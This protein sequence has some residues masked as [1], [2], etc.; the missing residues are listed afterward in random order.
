V[1]E[2]AGAAVKRVTNA[3][4]NLGKPDHEIEI[5][6][7]SRKAY[8]FTSRVE[9][10]G[11]LPVGTAGD[12]LAIIAGRDSAI[13]AW[14]IARRGAQLTIL[15]N[16]KSLKYAEALRKWHHGKKMD[17]ITNEKL[18]DMAKKYEV[19]AVV[20]GE[21]ADAALEK[22]IKKYKML[23]FRPLIALGRAETEELAA[24]IGI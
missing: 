21:K 16:K 22:E 15:T 18:A 17:M 6:V 2:N 12:V 4:V 11:G 23:H 3:R 5:E 19:H 8:V 9:A 1:A 7:R 14:A 10:A 24:K 20:T 13:A